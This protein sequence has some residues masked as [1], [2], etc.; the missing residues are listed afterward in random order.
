M[1]LSRFPRVRLAHLPTPLE[2]LPA[3]SR[4]LGGP[5]L[6]VKRDDCTGLATGGNKTRKLE[7]LMAD[8]LERG[9]DT[10]ITC[11]GVQSNHARQTAAAA[12]KL[13]LACHLVQQERAPWN[14]PDYRET[15]NLFLDRLL[16]A[17]F[18][19]VPSEVDRAPAMERVTDELRARGAR[20]YVIP[21]G[22]S[23]EIGGLGYAGCAL[24]IVE[25]ANAEDLAVDYV[26]LPSGGGGTQGGLVAGLAALNSG[27]RAIGIDIDA[28]GEAV[29]GRVHAVAAGT[30]ALLG[31]RGGV[32]DD[33]VSVNFDYAGEDYGRPTPEMVEAVT[34]LARIEG[35]VLDPVYSGKAMAGLIGL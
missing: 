16:G 31:V 21:G 26:V 6:Y 5:R 28:E 9:A 35:L 30:A 22:G 3:L 25:Q 14:D 20:P 19:S 17:H 7:F 10:V 13:G 27:I 12:A 33:A 1:Q 34:L 4:H 29:A 11:G 15:G 2:P 23:N 18:H 8:A 24:E 32:A